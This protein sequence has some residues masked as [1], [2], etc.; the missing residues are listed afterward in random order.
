MTSMWIPVVFTIA[1][2][3]LSVAA[4]IQLHHLLTDPTYQGDP[5]D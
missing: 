2:I 5:D 1:A 3:I 4:A